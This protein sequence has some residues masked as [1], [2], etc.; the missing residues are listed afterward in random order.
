MALLWWCWTGFAALGNLV[1]ADHGVL[2]LV[3][4]GIAAA[5]LAIAI[6]QALVDQPD[7]LHGPVVF[8]VSYLAVRAL[9]L[10]AL[11]FV[12][13][14]T[15]RNRHRT[16]GRARPH[17]R[18]T[19]TEQVCSWNARCPIAAEGPVPVADIEAAPVA[20]HVVDLLGR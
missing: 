7:D 6:P 20:H 13:S 11:V 8:A 14:A 3:G 5:A 15:D 10:S 16:S 1:R 17:R 2:P 4:F 9:T 12:F 19:T 18:P